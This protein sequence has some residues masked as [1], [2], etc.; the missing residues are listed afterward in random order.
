M[1]YGLVICTPVGFGSSKETID[2]V[3]KDTKQEA[4][5]YFNTKYPNLSLD[6]NGCRK[7]KEITIIVT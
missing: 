1:K 6:S 4:I 2:E 7:D 3:I 5:T